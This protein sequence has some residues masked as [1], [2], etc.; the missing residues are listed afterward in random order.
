[1]YRAEAGNAECCVWQLASFDLAFSLVPFQKNPQRRK[2][3]VLEGKE[4]GRGRTTR[5]GEKGGR[6]TKRGRQ[7]PLKCEECATFSH[8]LSSLSHLKNAIMS[9]ESGRS[10]DRS[11]SQFLNIGSRFPQ[12]EQYVS[13]A[14]QHCL[15]GGFGGTETIRPYRSCLWLQGT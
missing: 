13:Q 6:K 7:R 15:T 11:L 1:M 9:V 4:K 10:S 12:A 14:E 2:V 5:R 3:C 8:C